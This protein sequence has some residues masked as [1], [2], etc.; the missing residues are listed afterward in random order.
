MNNFKVLVDINNPSVRCRKDVDS[1]I[2]FTKTDYGYFYDDGRHT[3]H[4]QVAYDGDQN[5]ANK[6]KYSL[7]ITLKGIKTLVYE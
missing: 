1:H 5:T 2:H 6:I 4:Y 7:L 3:H